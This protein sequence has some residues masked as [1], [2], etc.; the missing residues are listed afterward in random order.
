VAEG[1]VEDSAA[2][3]RVEEEGDGVMEAE[4]VEK[5]VDSQRLSRVTNKVTRTQMSHFVEN[6]VVDG[7]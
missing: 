4:G 3:S 6:M 2:A 1:V 7:N 5:G